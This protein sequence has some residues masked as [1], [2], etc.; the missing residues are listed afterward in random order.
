VRP[1]WKGLHGLHQRH[2]PRV[3][4]LSV[5]M[6]LTWRHD[7]HG[8]IHGVVTLSV[9]LIATW[10][11]DIHGLCQRHHPRVVTLSVLLC[12]INQWQCIVPAVTSPQMSSRVLRIDIKKPLP[13][14]AANSTLPW[15]PTNRWQSG[16]DA[17]RARVG[18]GAL[19]PKDVFDRFIGT[20]SASVFVSCASAL[21]HG[22]QSI[23]AVMLRCAT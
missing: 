4:T 15:L 23:D 11:H 17:S 2:H 13:A 19:E 14:P 1:R 6:T 9:P 10:R 5:P 18:A 21:E 16:W 7:I 8:I 20:R 3:V 12:E 22:V